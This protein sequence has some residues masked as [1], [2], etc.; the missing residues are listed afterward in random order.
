MKRSTTSWPKGG[1][2][3]SKLSRT[4]GYSPE[5]LSTEQIESGRLPDGAGAALILPSSWALSEK[6]VQQMRLFARPAGAEAK[7]PF[8]VLLFDGVPGL[9]DSHGKIRNAFSDNLFDSRDAFTGDA[10]R[11]AMERLAQNPPPAGRSLAAWLANRLRPMPPVIPLPPEARDRVFRFRAP[12]G[13]LFAFERNVEYA[14]S[15]SLKQAGG[16]ESLEKPVSLDVTLP[17]RAHLYD[18]RA[19]TYLGYTDHLR[20]TLDPWRPALFAQTASKVPAGSILS[21]L[22]QPE[23]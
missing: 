5:F 12:G 18:L 22:S 21:F 15:E 20:F 17:R 13:R 14:M 7:R 4:L 3:G 9:F 19:Q 10:A 11:Y 2:A 16:N 23:R 8:H 1:T 6:E